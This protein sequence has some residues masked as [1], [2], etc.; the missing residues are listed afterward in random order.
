MIATA[1]NSISTGGF[2]DLVDGT[3]ASTLELVL[4]RG[5]AEALLYH[6]GTKASLSDGGP[7]VV[8]LER[9]TGGGAVVVEKL[10]VKALYANLGIKMEG[11]P[12]AFSFEGSIR[13]ARELKAGGMRG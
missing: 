7:F 12:G 5:P 1:S 13:R 9:I 4:G 8:G 10:I 11:I 6:I 3:V 2:N